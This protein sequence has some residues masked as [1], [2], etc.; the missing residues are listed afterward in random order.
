MTADA[1]LKSLEKVGSVSKVSSYPY[2]KIIVS[3]TRFENLSESERESLLAE[4]VGVAISELRHSASNALFL[5]RPVAPGEE[6]DSVSARGTHW[7]AGLT[8]SAPTAKAAGISTVHFYGYKGGQARST[9]LAEMALSLA[10]DGWRVLVVD[11]DIEAPSLDTLFA[12]SSSSFA[13]TLLGLVQGSELI[14][15][16]TVYVA[17]SSKRGL[18]DL[19]NCW[20]KASSYSIDAAA[21]ALRTALEPSILELALERIKSFAADQAYDVILIDHRTGISTSTLPV[22]SCMS[23]RVVVAVRLDEQW[24][25]AKPFIRLILKQSSPEPGLFAVWK[26]DAEDIR[27]FNQRTFRQKEDLLEMLADTFDQNDED[28][29]SKVSTTDISDHFVI[30]PYDSSFRAQRLPEPNTIDATNRDALARIRSLLRLGHRQAEP[31]SDERKFD[32]SGA[33]DEGDLILTR[34]LRELLA[35]ANPYSYILGRKGTGKTR[36][37][38]ELSTR[39]LGELLLVPDDST[40]QNG[41][42]SGSPEILD[43]IRAC[44]DK[45]EHFWLCLFDAGMKLGTTERGLLSAEFSREVSAS[46]TAGEI[47]AS[48]QSSTRTRLFLLDSLETTFVSRYMAVFLNSLFKVLSLIES[49]SRVADRVRFRLFLRR[50][51]A[52][53]GFVQNI[54]Q[55]LYGRALELSWDYQSILNFMLSRISK[56]AWFSEHFAELQRSIRVR[57]DTIREGAISTLECENLLLMAFP[58]TVKRNN[59]SFVTFLRTYFA[60]SASERGPNDSPSNDDVRRYYPRVLDDFLSQVSSQ[61]VDQSGNLLPA[62]EKGKIHQQRIFR[63]HEQAAN[64][65]LQGLK[66]ELAY[67]VNL[68]TDLAE[69]QTNIDRLLN[70][71]DGRQTPFRV[72]AL[73]PDLAQVTGLPAEAV[74]SAL[75]KMKDVGMFESRPDYPGEWRVGR[76]FKSSLRMKY[77]RGRATQTQLG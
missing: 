16:I 38:R 70:S 28:E 32:I 61:Q 75:E 27:S 39:G 34:A 23:G 57:E 59:L 22:M 76:L 29:E 14:E 9:L 63:S 11:A 40:E 8:G 26:P 15:P 20:P 3:S 42:R 69:N 62:L 6:S 66:Q 58:S 71:L 48:W 17:S 21:F 52:Q 13:S 67:L 60:D 33:R 77:V 65:Y 55:Q 56:N 1:L 35:P 53:P 5:I 24:Q 2:I 72:D 50:D 10:Q 4:E 47:V 45:P 43:A 73:V 49:D 41:I 51:L 44:I 30:W 68:S 7:L 36:L 64:N 25:P 19:M 46:R 18:V 54:E 31:D 12:A 37:A 74:R